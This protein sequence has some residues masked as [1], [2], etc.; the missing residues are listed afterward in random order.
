MIMWSYNHNFII[1]NFYLQPI[2]H[3]LSDQCHSAA[4]ETTLLDNRVDEHMWVTL[5]I[6]L[7]PAFF[8]N[9]VGLF[10]YTVPI[11]LSKVYS[12][13]L[14]SNNSQHKVELLLLHSWTDGLTR[15]QALNKPMITDVHFS[16]KQTHPGKGRL[17]YLKLESLRY[18]VIYKRT[19]WNSP[20]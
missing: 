15:A 4:T 17:V 20:W 3:S 18:S 13:F 14:D 16:P 2:P 10:M 1:K 9:M 11:Y 6:T 8:M 12:Q 7:R 19:G 5:Y